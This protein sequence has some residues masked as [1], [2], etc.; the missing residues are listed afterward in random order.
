LLRT[1]KTPEELQKCKIGITIA[2]SESRYC[3]FE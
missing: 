1:N 3:I 2:L